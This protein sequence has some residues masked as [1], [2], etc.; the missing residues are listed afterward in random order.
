ME[1]ITPMDSAL[2]GSFAFAKV[3]PKS[4]DRITDPN[5]YPEV[6]RVIPVI[7]NEIFGITASPANDTFPVKVN[8]E[9][10]AP[11][12]LPRRAVKTLD[13]TFNRISLP[14]VAP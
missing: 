3:N 14:L 8:P 5:V 2:S 7:L 13:D 4:F 9:D 1:D 12:V 11:S 6:P 10:I